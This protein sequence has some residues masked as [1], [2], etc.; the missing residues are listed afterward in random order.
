MRLFLLLIMLVAPS[1][2]FGQQGGDAAGR[3]T[4]L[5]RHISEM[6]ELLNTRDPAVRDAAIETALR[7]PSPA[8]RGLAIYYALRRYDRL[9]LGFALPAGSPIR[10]EDLPSLVL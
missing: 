6:R 8:I 9:P 10:R 1:S 2:A 4:E 5:S 7:D 3:V